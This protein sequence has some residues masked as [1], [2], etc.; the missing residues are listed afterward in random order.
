MESNQDPQKTAAPT[1]KRLEDLPLWARYTAP[2]NS[3]AVLLETPIP[4]EGL[5]SKR[6]AIA[7]RDR[8]VATV[9]AESVR[10]ALSRLTS[11]ERLA[12]F[13]DYCSSCGDAQP[14]DPRA[15]RCQCWNDD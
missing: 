13:R 12:L 15:R 1:E 2:P 11:E 14:D 5:V 4:Y 10:E 6:D 3:L 8:E 9:R 7:V